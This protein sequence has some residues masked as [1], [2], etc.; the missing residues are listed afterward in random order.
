[1]TKTLFLAIVAAALPL[2]AA[3]AAPAPAAPQGKPISRVDF[4]KTID[5]RFNQM[6]TNHD[7]KVTKEELAAELQRELQGANGKIRQQLE[8]KFRQLDTNHDGQLSLSEFMAI[9]P[10]VHASESPDQM[11]QRLDTNHDGKVTA[12]EFRAPD[13][14]KFN[15]AD[16]NHD[17]IVTP[18]EALAYARA[19]G[20][21]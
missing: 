15:A 18:A 10:Q 13:L 4:L 20:G 2:A 17:G 9:Q 14:A 8:M 19:H 3:S 6:D 21:H 11:L 16:A 7:G 12:E 1:M 5:T